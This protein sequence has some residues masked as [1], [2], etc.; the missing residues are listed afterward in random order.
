MRTYGHQTI[1]IDGKA[2]RIGVEVIESNDDIEK[3]AGRY[4][5]CVGCI[6]VLY[7]QCTDYC[8]MYKQAKSVDPRE[9]T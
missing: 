3:E 9:L 7:P 5:A 8:A 6:N 2:K 1:F 4:I